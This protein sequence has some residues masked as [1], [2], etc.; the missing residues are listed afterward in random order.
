MRRAPPRFF[1]F[2]PEE[3]ASDFPAGLDVRHFLGLL[4][5]CIDDFVLEGGTCSVVS[6]LAARILIEPAVISEIEQAGMTFSY[7]FAAISH[8]RWP[9]CTEDC[10]SQ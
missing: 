8:G 1:G 10:C 2:A 5:F 9:S 3:F 4:K 6:P 7:R